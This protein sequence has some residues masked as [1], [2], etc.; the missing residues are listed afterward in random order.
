MLLWYP[1][2]TYK[3]LPVKSPLTVQVFA[4]VAS[5]AKNALVFC[6]AA[7]PKPRVA[8]AVAPLCT[9]NAPPLATIKLPVVALSPANVGKLPVALIVTL[10]VEP[11][12]VDI[13]EPP[14]MSS[15]LP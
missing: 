13:A 4:P 10:S 11:T 6:V 9:V 2:V 8:L 7:V 3:S 12:T 5:D 14:S 15:V 1:V